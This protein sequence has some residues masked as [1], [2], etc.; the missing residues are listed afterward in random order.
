MRQS[1]V[2]RQFRCRF[3]ISFT[4][5]ARRQI[6][7]NRV[8]GRVTVVSQCHRVLLRHNLSRYFST[9][10]HAFTI[11]R[12]R[13]ERTFGVCIVFYPLICLH[14]LRPVPP[15]V[16]FTDQREGSETLHT[17]PPQPRR[18]TVTI[19]TEFRPYHS[20]LFS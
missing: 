3:D 17:S 2:P 9:V 5:F 8:G 15:V 7:S 4:S 19:S 11:T 12:R 16:I 18:R 14:H 13:S 20:K 1:G 6:F 10:G